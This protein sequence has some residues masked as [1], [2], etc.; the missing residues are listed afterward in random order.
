LW[1]PQEVIRRIRATEKTAA[2]IPERYSDEL[3]DDPRVEPTN[4][5]SGR[6]HRFAVIQREESRCSKTAG[7]AEAFAAFAGVIKT[8]MRQGVDVVEWLSALFRGIGPRS[9]PT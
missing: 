8:V 6:G 1:S 3:L 5:I 4:K 7:G 9:A 2:A